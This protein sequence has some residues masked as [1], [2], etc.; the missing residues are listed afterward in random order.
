MRTMQWNRRYRSASRS[1]GGAAKTGG[2]WWRGPGRGLI[3]RGTATYGEPTPRWPA[4]L[5][6]HGNCAIPWIAQRKASFIATRRNARS[7]MPRR[8]KPRRSHPQTRTEDPAGEGSLRRRRSGSR[9]IPSDSDNPGSL[10]STDDELNRAIVRMLQEDGRMPFKTIA[11][12]LGVSQGTV[13]NRFAWMKS[14][15]VLEI[16]A[17]ADPSSINYRTDA[18]LGINVAPTSTPAD[19]AKRLMPFNEVVYV[20]WVSG[21][22]DLL[23]EVVCDSDERFHEFLLNECYGQTDIM[24]IEIMTSLSMYKNQFLL[25]RTLTL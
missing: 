20:I 13:R 10:S 1:I 8:S 12:T 16:V 7:I 5:S 3:Y 21:R 24:D 11:E 23:V 18:M 15:G 4:L 6:T 2:A 19:V 25:K 22:Y 17:V 14:A 9:I